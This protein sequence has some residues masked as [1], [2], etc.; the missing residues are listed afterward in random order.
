VWI[1]LD[2]YPVDTDTVGFEVRSMVD[3]FPLTRSQNKHGKRVIVDSILAAEPC[4]PS[5]SSPLGGIESMFLRLLQCLG[6]RALHRRRVPKDLPHHLRLG[7]LGETAALEHL[8]R[9]GLKFLVSNFAGPRGE[10]DLI[11]RERDCLVFVEVKTRSCED[12]ARPAAAVD[13]RKRRRLSLTALDYLRQIGNPRVRFRFDIVEVLVE[14]GKVREIR[15][16][17]NAFPLACRNYFP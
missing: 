1:D 16:L 11:L 5:A 15:H 12:W 2:P 6:S 7:R 14:D 13:Q 9:Q 10:I 4:H 8:R 3:R 17:P